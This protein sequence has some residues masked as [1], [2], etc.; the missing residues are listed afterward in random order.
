MVLN[1]AH[2]DFSN[3]ISGFSTLLAMGFGCLIVAFPPYEA[4]NA[5]QFHKE[6]ERGKKPTYFRLNI[7]FYDFG[8]VNNWQFFYY[9]QFFLRRFLYTIMLVAWPQDKYLTLSLS[10]IMHMIAMLYIVYVKPFNSH[11]RNL[12]TL[13]T[14]IGL[15]ALHACLFAF[16][17]A[18]P[19]LDKTHFDTYAFIFGLILLIIICANLLFVTI[20]SWVP[21][22][23]LAVILNIIKEEEVDETKM[24][25]IDEFSTSGEGESSSEQMEV[26][27]KTGA[28]DADYDKDDNKITLEDPDKP[29]EQEVVKTRSNRP[30]TP[31]R[32]VDPL[33]SQFA[34]KIEFKEPTDPYETA[35]IQ[36]P[37]KIDKPAENKLSTPIPTQTA[38]AKALTPLKEETPVNEPISTLQPPKD[39]G[40]TVK[41]MLTPAIGNFTGGDFGKAL[42]ESSDD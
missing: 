33:V 34:P 15:V 38:P 1:L 21:L 30:S 36:A 42:D 29:K 26:G 32:G 4:W 10:T 25:I 14:E 16:M 27:S 41:K 3:V 11:I 13:F 18:S 35:P 37:P 28:Y 6:L 22:K 12:A 7:L 40:P 20:D 8:L 39:D 31:P 2:G 17:Q 24:R 19:N 9:W 23:K 5:I